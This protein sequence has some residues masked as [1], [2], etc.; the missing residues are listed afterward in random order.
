MLLFQFAGVAE[1]W[2]SMD[3]WAN[4]REWGHH[5]DHGE[6][7][8]ACPPRTAHGVAQLVP[9]QRATGSA[10]RPTAR[11]AAGGGADDGHLEHR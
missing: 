4:L 8:A 5:P 6:V 11:A 3:D 7:V 1:Q 10:R 2:L 9:G